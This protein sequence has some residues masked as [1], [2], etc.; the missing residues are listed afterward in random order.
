MIIVWQQLRIQDKII[1]QNTGKLIISF[2]QLIVIIQWRFKMCHA[3]CNHM[4]NSIKCQNKWFQIIDILGIGRPTYLTIS[5]LTSCYKY[6]KKIKCINFKNIFKSI[7]KKLPI[8]HSFLLEHIFLVFKKCF[9]PHQHFHS[10]CEK[11]HLTI[12]NNVKQP[13]QPDQ[14]IELTF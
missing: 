12:L 2:P 5:P 7:K 6:L 13:K 11:S 8:I 1:S 14:Q 10:G 3:T 4:C 9:W